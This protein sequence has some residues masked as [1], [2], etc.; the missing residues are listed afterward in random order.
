MNWLIDLRGATQARAGLLRPGRLVLVVG[1]SGA[2]KDTLIA[3]ARVWLRDC[4]DVRFP[5][6]AVTRPASDAED[7]GA[8]TREECARAAAGGAFALSW[9]AH[10]HSYGVPKSV[11]DDI[12]A[13]CTVV[14]NVSRAIVANAR[15]RYL[16][17]A[18][19]LVTAPR[20]ILESRI[21]GRGR[22]SGEAVEERLKREP[23]LQ[24]ALEPDFV[25]HNAG[26]PDA[27]IRRLVN[28][29]RDA[30]VFLVT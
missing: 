28:A 8:M 19:V 4:P 17:V 18:V 22:E 30:G 14:C 1:P 16:H 2:G 5:R 11:D 29:I 3:G 6:L 12:R 10:G 15:R 27:G 9:D 13:G 7:N 24:A 20:G 21:A 26:R 25:I 23:A